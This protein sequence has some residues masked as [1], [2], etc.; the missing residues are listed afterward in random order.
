[1]DHELNIRQ[2]DSHTKGGC[3]NNDPMLSSTEPNLL[4]GFFLGCQATVVFSN[5]TGVF[6]L[7]FGGNGIYGLMGVTVNDSAVRIILFKYFSR[8]EAFLCGCPLLVLRK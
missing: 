2:V 4:M 6:L 1:M 7:Q 8:G 3:G 5:L